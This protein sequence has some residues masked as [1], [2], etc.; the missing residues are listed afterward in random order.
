MLPSGRDAGYLRISLSQGL[1]ELWSIS[2]LVEPFLCSYRINAQPPTVADG[3]G[4]RQ[5]SLWPLRS[6]IFLDCRAGIVYNSGCG[7]YFYEVLR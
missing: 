3:A 7:L 4:G 6:L 1:R 5:F 2:W